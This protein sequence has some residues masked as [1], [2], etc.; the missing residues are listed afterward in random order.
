MTQVVRASE[1]TIEEYVK[2][3]DLNPDN[4][5]YQRVASTNVT[6]SGAQWQITSPNK[7]ALLLSWAAVEWGA[8]ITRQRAPGAVLGADEN[9]QTTGFQVSFKPVLPFSNAMT[10]QTVSVN[11][12]SITMSQ[13]RRFSE[14]IA[15]MCVGKSES[16]A[17]YGTE[18]W[19]SMG[20]SYS[21]NRP[22]IDAQASYVDHGLRRNEALLKQNMLSPVNADAVLTLVA[23]NSRV[24]QYTE[25]LLA[26]PFNAFAKVQSGMPRYMP[27]GK[28]SPMIPNVDRIEIDVQFD[29]PRLAASCLFYRYGFT[30]GVNANELKALRISALTANLLLYWYEVP[31]DMS[32]PRSPLLQT[33]NIREFQTQLG[34]IAN[35]AVRAAISTD[36]FQLRSVPSLILLHARRR[37]DIDAYKCIDLSNDADYLGTTAVG[38]SDPTGLVIASNVNHSLDSF[39]EIVRLDII[40]GDRPNVISASFSQRELYQLLVKNSKYS[41]FSIPFKDWKGAYTTR[42]A[43]AANAADENSVPQ[44]VVDAQGSKS[45]LAL[46]P[47]D[48]AEKI[49]SGISF[50]NSLQF[51][52]VVRGKDGA[53]GLQ[54]GNQE[55][56]LYT[57]IITGKHW[58]RL[59][60]DRAEFQEQQI[61]L[62][63]A[64]RMQRPGLVASSSSLPSGGAY[65]S[66]Y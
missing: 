44:L 60:S 42:Q 53:C 43:A 32:V 27:W 49:S 41:D 2:S 5:F 66:R 37:S 4:V 15:R 52:V 3:L 11:G 65:T 20:G 46:Q 28:Q 62:E 1:L 61:P 22:G 24:V 31:F 45:F 36:L 63:A 16:R 14:P 23:T 9:F 57:H 38:S 25:P 56:T 30:A 8:T 6:T 51:S 59:E 34:V 13:P 35:N 64:E 10:S 18:W 50:P 39:A 40:L 55:Y 19:D 29:E 26:P 7:R 17:C 21:N 47:K 33:W 48:I 58:L 54:G 12:N